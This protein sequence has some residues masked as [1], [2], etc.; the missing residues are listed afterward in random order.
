MV[1]KRWKEYD[2]IEARHLNDINDEIRRIKKWMLFAGTSWTGFM[3]LLGFLVLF[4]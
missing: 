3:G 1:L 2:V 4:T